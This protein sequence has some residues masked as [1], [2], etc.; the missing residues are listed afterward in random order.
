MKTKTLVPKIDSKNISET[1]TFL[2]DKYRF[3]KYADKQYVTVVWINTA[4]TV[5]KLLDG[6]IDGLNVSPLA[7]K[8]F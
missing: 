2:V 6:K 5:V 7:Q 8:N 1:V 4:N 3:R